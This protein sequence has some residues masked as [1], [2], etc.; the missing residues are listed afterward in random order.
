MVSLFPLLP[1]ARGQSPVTLAGTTFGVAV[2]DGSYPFNNSGYCFLIANNSGNNLF[3]ANLTGFTNQNSP[4]NYTASGANGRIN[5]NTAAYGQIVD[6]LQFSDPYFGNFT[7]T[8]A[9]FGGQQQGDFIWFNGQAPATVA[10]KVFACNINDGTDPLPTSGSAVIH[11]STTGNTYTIYKDGSTDAD[12]SGTYSYTK[13][14]AATARLTLNDSR[15]GLVTALF[16]FADGWSGSFGF[17]NDARDSFAV[18]DFQI[19]DTTPPGLE[20]TAPKNGRTLSNEVVTISGRAA[21]NVSV[22]YVLYSLN[23][24]DWVATDSTNDYQTW[25]ADVVL[26]PGTNLFY[27]YAVDTSGNPSATIA[28]RYVYVVSAPLGVVINGRGSVTPA[29]NNSLLQIG[30]N[31]TVTALPGVGYS[32]TGWSDGTNLISSRPALAFTMAAG[33]SLVANFADTARPS[34]TLLSP[35]AGQRLSNSLITVTGRAADNGRV[36]QV[37]VSLNES[38]WVPANTANGWTNWSLELGELRPGGNRLKAYAVDHVGNASFTNSLDFNYVLS[39]PIGL[40]LSGGGKISPFNHGARLAIGQ[41]YSITASASNGFAFSAWKNAYGAVLTNKPAVSFVMESNLDLTAFFND[42]ARPS[43]TITKKSGDLLFNDQFANVSGRA[44]DNAGV[45]D[46]FYKVN[47]GGW[48]AASSANGWA[49]WSAIA[50]LLPGT[51][52]FSAYAVD[53]N[54]NASAP[55]STRIIY[56]TAPASLNNISADGFSDSGPSFNLSFTANNFC[57]VSTDTNYLNGVGTYTY[58]R[59]TPFTGKLRI[60]Y[61]APPLAANNRF[62]DFSL[63]FNS[64]SSARFTNLTAFDSGRLALNVTPSLA[65][66]SLVKRTVFYVNDNGVGQSHYFNAGKFLVTD[67]LTGATNAGTTL[68]YAKFSPIATLLRQTNAAGQTYTVS[69]YNGENFGTTYLEKYRPDGSLLGTETGVFG[70]AAQELAGNAPGNLANRGL[71]VFQTGS[72]FSLAFAGTTFSQQSSDEVYESGVGAYD[73][74][75]SDANTLNLTLNYL[76]PANLNGTSSSATFSFFAPN[77]AYLVN[78]DGAIGAAVLAPI[79]S[80]AI[81]SPANKTYWLTNKDTGEVKK[82]QFFGDGSFGISGN[83]TA[84]GTYSY[85]PFSPRTGMAQLMFSTGAYSGNQGWLQLNFDAGGKGNYKHSILDSGNQLL[86]VQRGDFGQ[87]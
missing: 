51:N 8:S 63:Y 38:G 80:P 69:K 18:G 84:G 37:Y 82:Y 79:A 17:R 41:R 16:A 1:K 83:S 40:H 42:V 65:I 68:A 50:M 5:L 33:L 46:V 56:A 28:A 77:L 47:D 73:F 53:A 71:T 54:G 67:L 4:Y 31:Y 70:F 30:A 49:D 14:N 81:T 7:L 58:T 43:L 78:A 60:N 35:L 87:Q 75:L 66:T 13:A 34:I 62:R 6:D 85:S 72:A 25:T 57:Q 74:V 86:N 32:F 27:V 61:T 10:G 11:F 3:L 15:L 64:A 39:A 21:D 24:A 23:G 36:A 19:L 12:S 48:L 2:A 26:N 45:A 52:T 22:L 20:I 44:S 9:T 76:A 29:Y 59:L 55:I